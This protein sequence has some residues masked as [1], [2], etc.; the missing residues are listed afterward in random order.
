M[1]TSYSVSPLKAVTFPELFPGEKKENRCQDFITIVPWLMSFHSSFHLL[2]CSRRAEQSCT[3]STAET[4]GQLKA[5]GFRKWPFIANIRKQ[6]HLKSDLDQSNKIASWLLFL[7]PVLTP[8]QTTLPSHVL[9]LSCPPPLTVLYRPIKVTWWRSRK[10][11]KTFSNY[12]LLL[13]MYVP[14]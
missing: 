1:Y 2:H 10:K 5:D 13:S 9:T 12:T 14:R 7:P 8:L 6:I 3:G 4:L 11:Q